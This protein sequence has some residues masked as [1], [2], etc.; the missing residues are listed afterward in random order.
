MGHGQHVRADRLGWYLDWALNN[1]HIVLYEVCI[2]SRSQSVKL[3]HIHTLC[4]CKIWCPALLHC[5]SWVRLVL[6]SNALSSIPT[7]SAS[8]N[9][10]I[11]KWPK[12]FTS[13]LGEP[14]TNA[15]LFSSV[16]EGPRTRLAHPSIKHWKL[17][18]L[19][20]NE[21][22]ICI[23]YYTPMNMWPKMVVPKLQVAQMHFK[24]KK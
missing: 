16:I 14:W 5:S 11:T 19:H 13:Q 4:A 8:E 20:E 2:K 15:R 3:L 10:Y 7:R 24:K 9:L 21:V 6:F 12:H 23:V 1:E 18:E 22:K 17:H